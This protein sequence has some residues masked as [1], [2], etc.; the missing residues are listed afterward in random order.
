MITSTAFSTLSLRS[1]RKIEDG[2]IGVETKQREL[3][4]E[5]G[6]AHTILRPSGKILVN[7]KVYDANSEYGF[8]EKGETVKIVR[9]ETGQLYV[10][11]NS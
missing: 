2:F 5:A 6:V 11:K 10:I 9:Y 7:D 1:E 8:I 3:V 4:G